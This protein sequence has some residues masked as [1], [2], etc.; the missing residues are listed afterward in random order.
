MEREREKVRGKEGET[1]GQMKGG[2]GQREEGERE[3]WRIL[4]SHYF[5][6]NTTS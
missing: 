2:G 1:E 4:L 5:T 3:G 6:Y